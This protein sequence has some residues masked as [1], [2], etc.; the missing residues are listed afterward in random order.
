M[1]GISQTFAIF[2]HREQWSFFKGFSHGHSDICRFSSIPNHIFWI[3][4]VRMQKFSWPQ[5]SVCQ[6]SKQGRPW[7]DLQEQS[8]LVFHCFSRPF[9]SQLVFIILENH[10]FTSILRICDI[11]SKINS[12]L[13][14]L[15]MVGLP[16]RV[17]VQLL[18]LNTCRK[19]YN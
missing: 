12:P 14:Y 2:D 10:C 11:S 1:S 4:D 6:D 16:L 19:S 7:S 3:K 18:I 17:W 9:F 5:L 15:Y 8:D 13:K